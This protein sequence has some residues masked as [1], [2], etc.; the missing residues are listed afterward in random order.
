VAVTVTGVLVETADVVAVNVPLVAPA[1][2]VTLAGTDATALLLSSAITAPPEGAPAVSV[3]VPV[4]GLPPVTDVGLRVT[5]LKAAGALA[6]VCSRTPTE[7]RKKSR[8]VELATLITR[9]R[10]SALAKFAALQVRPHVSAAP[11][12]VRAVRLVPSVLVIFAVVQVTP[13]SQES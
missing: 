4:E 2:I 9:K 12:K 10:K 1:P 6:P 11:P 8:E 7:S 3:S 13:P 5:A